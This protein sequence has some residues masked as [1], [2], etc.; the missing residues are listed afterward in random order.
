MRYRPF[1]QAGLAVSAITLTLDEAPISRAQRIELVFA[2]LESGINS[3]ELASLSPDCTAAVRA[4]VDA[5]GRDVLVLL[6]RRPSA[7]DVVGGH[8]AL[9]SEAM[10]C[11][12]Q[13]GAQRFDAV[14]IKAD[15][16]PSLEDA[17]ALQALRA[18]GLTRMIGVA[19]GPSGPT[20]DLTVGYDLI[21]TPFGLRSDA[22]L[23]K[24]LRAMFENNITLM[25]F[26]F[27]ERIQP[28]PAP[29]APKGLN[30]LFKRAPV[31]A[32]PDPYEFLHRTPDWTAEALALAYAL[33]ETTLSTIR[34]QTTDI[35]TLHRLAMAVE[36]ELPIGAAAQ[37]E[38]ARFSAHA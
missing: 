24:R 2:A 26:D 7:K 10:A 15:G 16:S 32:E 3:F 11:L 18:E 21:A 6:L 36:R 17:T 4:A 35:A 22:G 20:V 37:I 1:N 29:E 27:D 13:I 34:V 9:T 8:Q 38:M 23:R 28:A 33:T 5:A 30:R 31:A 12:E 14:L 19:C 25:G